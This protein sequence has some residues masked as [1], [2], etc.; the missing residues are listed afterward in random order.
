MREINENPSW[1]PPA[2]PNG[3]IKQIKRVAAPAPEL[4]KGIAKWL[5]Y[6]VD[7]D[8]SLSLPNTSLHV[9]VQK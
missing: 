6:N 3:S 7:F 8:T 4:S 9:R 1:F 2:L 5:R